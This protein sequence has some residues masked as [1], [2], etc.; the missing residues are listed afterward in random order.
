[1]A[2]T[3]NARKPNNKKGLSKKALER[4]LEQKKAEQER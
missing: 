2:T 1:M 4:I 3:N